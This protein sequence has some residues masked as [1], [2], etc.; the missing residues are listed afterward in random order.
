MVSGIIRMAKTTINHHIQKYH[1][2]L[3]DGIAMHC[4]HGHRGAQNCE[5]SSKNTIKTHIHEN[6]YPVPKAIVFEI[7]RKGNNNIPPHRDISSCYKR[8]QQW[9]DE[10]SWDKQQKHN[11]K[12]TS[13]KNTYRIK[14]KQQSTTIKQIRSSL[15]CFH[16]GR[17]I[18]LKW[19][20]QRGDEYQAWVCEM[21][22]LSCWRN[23]VASE[24]ML[25]T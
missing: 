7:I 22:F 23:H 15:S 21:E 25:Q 6:T 11:W 3:M 8:W 20:R 4:P 1:R 5:T 9:R 14:A 24:F 16:D 17:V 10:Q 12:N 19:R 2:P 13:M 18:S